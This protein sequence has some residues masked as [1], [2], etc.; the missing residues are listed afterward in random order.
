MMYPK[1]IYS[2]MQGFPRSL[3]SQK[4]VRAYVLGEI[5]RSVLVLLQNHLVGPEKLQTGP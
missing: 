5:R 4:R 2:N 3:N 1:A